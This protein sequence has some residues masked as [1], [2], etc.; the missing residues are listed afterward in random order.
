MH[1]PDVLSTL[2]SG[3][4]LTQ[5]EAKEA[6]AAV[7]AGEATPSQIAAFIV[8]LRIKGETVEE[9]TGLVESMREA[10]VRVDVGVPVVD[11]VGTGGDR[12]GTFNISTTAAFIAAG[13]GCT[14]AKHG[15]RSASSKCGSADVLEALGI[16]IDLEPEAT[17]E[18]IRETGFGFFYAPRYHPAMRHAGPVRKELGIPTV[19]NFLGPLANPAGATRMAVGVSDHKMAERMVGV[20]ARLGAEY[21]FVVYGEDGLDEVTTTGPTF[22][23]RLRDGEITHAEFTPEDFG[24]PRS[25]LGD[26]L[27][28]DAVENTAITRDILGGVGGPK[29]D[30]AV[31]NAAAAIVAAGLAPG[32][33]EAVEQAREAIDSGR[34]AE[35]L[36][37]VVE[38][39]RELAA[40]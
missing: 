40:I 30:I 35:V 37:N 18:L 27:G 28:G 11:V 8:A 24:V 17:V 10:A 31:V 14:V 38:R 19:F 15:N 34:A 5:A 4:D 13:A 22:I 33:V 25:Q 39:S 3:S 12:S 36:E 2:A 23:Y 21:A 32:F 7:M 9:M 6:M 20:L 16:V 29:R 1:W 26:L